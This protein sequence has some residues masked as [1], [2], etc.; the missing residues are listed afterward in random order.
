MDDFDIHNKP[1]VAT[2]KSLPGS[3]GAGIGAKGGD[4][5]DAPTGDNAPAWRE[6][7]AREM[8]AGMEMDINPVE[9]SGKQKG[10]KK[11]QHKM[12]NA[13]NID[14]DT[15]SLG[16]RKNVKGKGKGKLV[17]IDEDMEIA[18]SK[19]IVPK[20]PAQGRSTAWEVASDGNAAL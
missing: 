2:K 3:R 4:G 6:W 16:E 1:I 18:A 19:F 14:V 9:M 20:L 7:K 8:G 13:I 10:R 5:S 17:R 15:A 12:I 11:S